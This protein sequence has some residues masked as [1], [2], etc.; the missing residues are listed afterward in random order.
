MQL[1]PRYD[2]PPVLVIDLLVDPAPAVIRQ[3]RR[4]VELLAGLDAEQWATPSR[5][6]R[7]TVREVAAHLVDVDAFWVATTS[8]ALAGN[9]TRFLASFDPVTTPAALVDARGAASP[10]DV[11]DRL[12]DG[13]EAL[14]AV[15]AGI[16]GEQWRLPAEA[17]PGHV[18][19]HVMARHALW[20]AWVHER[21]IALPL[22]IEP[23]RDHEE[24]RLSLEYA[25]ALAPAFLAMRGSTRT[26]ALAVEATDPDTRFVVLAGATVA[27]RHDVDPPED[28]LCLA[29]DAVELLEAL[30][31]RASLAGEVPAERRWLLD[32]LA[33]VFDV[34]T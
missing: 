31:V 2:G 5:C 15:L 21:D 27:V 11:L 32:G 33:T 8:A 30:S 34:A 26:G 24:I 3:R 14:A 25:A 13:V 29:G 22:G 4:L 28:A 12:G 19:L 7:W 6:E 9:P 10:A 23:V 1:T 18:A 16:D 17:P 20:D